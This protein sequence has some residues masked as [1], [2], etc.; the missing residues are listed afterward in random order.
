M[1]R[2]C[3]ETIKNP[4]V[5]LAK[6]QV[7]LKEVLF[8]L[9]DDHIQYLRATYPKITD[10]DC[11][12]CCLKLCEMDDQTIAYCFGNTSKQIVVQRRLRLKKKMKESNE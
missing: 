8:E 10:D 2:E 1:K 9:Y 5:L 6:E 4:K 11:I 7:Q 3:D 12:Y